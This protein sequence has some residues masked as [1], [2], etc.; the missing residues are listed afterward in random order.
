MVDDTDDIVLEE[1]TDEGDT[2]T[3]EQ[4]LK[5]LRDKLRAAQTEATTN[6]AGWQRA[7]AD[8]VNLMKR[9]RDTDAEL[10]HKG[11]ALA[12]DIISVFDSIEAA[13]LE[14]VLRQLDSTLERH[15]IV[16]FAPPVGSSFDPTVAEAVATVAT[17]D[18]A[19]DNTIHSVMQSGYVHGE[20][21]LRP[22]RVSVYHKQ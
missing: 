10:G 19:L 20:L 11:T 12:R 15:S 14:S 3:P 8:Y 4:K 6:L 16:R 17:E 21:T 5:K 2:G 7:K 9:M 22:A 1:S 18:E 13:G